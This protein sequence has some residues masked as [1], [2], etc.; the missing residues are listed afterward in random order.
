MKI[1]NLLTFRRRARNSDPDLEHVH[2]RLTDVEARSHHAH[3]RAVDRGERNHFTEAWHTL[4]NR[5][6]NGGAQ[7]G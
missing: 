3:R 1:R 5:D 2:Q 4:L 7:H 6:A